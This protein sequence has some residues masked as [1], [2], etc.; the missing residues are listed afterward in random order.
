MPATQRAVA[1][2]VKGTQRGVG[3]TDV[4]SGTGV[5]DY[6]VREATV[7][8]TL[9][10]DQYVIYADERVA[11]F[12]GMAATFRIPTPGAVAGT[13]IASLWLPAGSGVIVAVRRFDIQTEYWTSST[14]VRN[15]RANRVTAAPT[16]GFAH[17]PVPF[18]STYAAAVAVFRGAASADD[19]IAT[20]TATPTAD[21]WGQLHTHNV[22]TAMR[23][24]IP[25]D[26]MVPLLSEDDPIYLR[27]GE[28]LLVWEPSTSPTTQ[29]G[30]SANCMWEEFTLP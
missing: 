17:A 11:A 18:D 22:S 14:G 21:G 23:W 1:T 7:A 28:G 26:P 9:A 3:V 30:W 24:R 19:T 5:A 10:F 25:D 27:P 16:G 20:L 6:R 29:A 8:G 2:Q 13:K 15:Y 4:A 12:K